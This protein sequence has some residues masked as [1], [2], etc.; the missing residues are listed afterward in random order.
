VLALIEG[1][2]PEPTTRRLRAAMRLAPLD[3]S[4]FNSIVGLG[5]ADFKG[6]SRLA[7]HWME[8]G[9]ALNPRAVWTYRNLVPAYIAAGDQAASERG[10]SCLLNEYPSFNIAAACSA[11]VF[12]RPTMARLEDGL[13]R[14]GLCRI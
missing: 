10:I 2:M 4:I 9:L 1:F 12:S 11:M 3:P 14:A 13:S 7:I 8:R 6:Q 5:V